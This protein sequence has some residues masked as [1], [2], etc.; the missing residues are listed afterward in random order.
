MLFRSTEKD[1]TLIPYTNKII[2]TIDV[3]TLTRGDRIKLWQYYAEVDA[4]K[5]LDCVDLGSRYTLTRGQISRASSMHDIGKIAI[6]D[7]ILLK[8]GKLEQTE[9]EVM[10][11]HTTKGCEIINT[12]NYINDE[13]YLGYAYE[14]CRHHHERYDGK[15]YP[16]GLYY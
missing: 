6:P 16:D 13:E 9:F 14:I 5:G 12:I 15:G 7:A 11:L 2:F 3:P 10:K 8:P 4:I 1:L